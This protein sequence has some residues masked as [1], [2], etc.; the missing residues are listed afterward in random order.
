MLASRK[1]KFSDSVLVTIVKYC[2]SQTFSGTAS[3]GIGGAGRK[4]ASAT[5]A[6]VFEWSWGVHSHALGR[7]RGVVQDETSV[8]LELVPYGEQRDD[9]VVVREV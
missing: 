2:G 6:Q 1:G 9:R 4:I 5:W 3:S 8:A 7:R